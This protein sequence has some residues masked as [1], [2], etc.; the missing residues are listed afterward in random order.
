MDILTLL[1]EVAK[2]VIPSLVIFLVTYSLMKSFFDS[3]LNIKHLEI[4]AEMAKT[5]NPLKLQAYERLILLMERLSPESLVLRVHRPGVA[6]SQIKMD[7]ISDINSEFNHNLSQQLYV[8]QQSWVV[9]K[10][11]KEELINIIN[12]A[13]QELG[14]NAVGLDLSKAIFD[15][16]MKLEVSPTQKALLF[17]KREFDI[18]FG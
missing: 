2:Y 18:V 7:L 15:K 13:F 5:I 12:I 9:V 1:I 17:L 3:Q 10:A 6:A 8:S 16:I 4:K 14:P 11:T